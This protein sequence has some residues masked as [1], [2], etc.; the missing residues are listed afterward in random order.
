MKRSNP[1]ALSIIEAV[2]IVGAC[3]GAAWMVYTAI[4]A[5]GK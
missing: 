4:G 3:A 5:M 2:I 1:I